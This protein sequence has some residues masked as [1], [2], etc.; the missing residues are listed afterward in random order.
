MVRDS[1]LDAHIGTPAWSD[2]GGWPWEEDF[3]R[4]HANSGPGAAD[5]P[6]VEGRPQLTAEEAAEH[7][8]D[9]YLR[10]DDDWTPWA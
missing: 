6:A 8:R 1:H 7:T 2:M 4:E 9:V 5:G 3:L 10:G